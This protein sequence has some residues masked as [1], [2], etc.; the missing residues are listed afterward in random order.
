MELL[1]DAEPLLRQMQRL[2][3]SYDR[4]DL[5]ALR[6]SHTLSP[7]FCAKMTRD[8]VENTARE[9]REALGINASPSGEEIKASLIF[10]LTVCSCALTVRRAADGDVDKL[11][12]KAYRNDL[13]DCIYAAYATLFDGLVSCDD[14]LVKTYNLSLKLLGTVFDCRNLTAEETVVAEPKSN[15]MRR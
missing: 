7:R 4:R 11:G 15:A 8:V 12:S 5:K 10:R 14:G 3:A 9:L 1:G 13:N 6:S 2:I